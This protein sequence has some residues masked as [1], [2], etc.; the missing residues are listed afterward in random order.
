M[1]GDVGVRVGFSSR[2]QNRFIER[3]GETFRFRNI[4]ERSFL[5]VD[6]HEE[7]ILVEIKSFV[8]EDD[9]LIQ[10]N[11]GW[12]EL[13][14][15]SEAGTNCCWENGDVETIIGESDVDGDVAV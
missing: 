4:V 15:A 3:D 14:V 9:T 5:E 1:D 12:L 7:L 8:G 2:N 10:I 6:R 11:T 13:G